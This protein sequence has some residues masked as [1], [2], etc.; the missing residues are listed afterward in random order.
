M[1]FTKIIG[2]SFEIKNLAETAINQLNTYW[3]LPKANGET[4]FTLQN[5]LTA[6]PSGYYCQENA[7][8]YLPVW[9]EPKEYDV[10]FEELKTN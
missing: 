10:T 3:K 6:Y 2:Y 8:W 4:V 5:T 1:E 7:D 9:G